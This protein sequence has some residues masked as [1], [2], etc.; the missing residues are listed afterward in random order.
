M[1]GRRAVL[2]WCANVVARAGLRVLRMHVTM[3]RGLCQEDKTFPFFVVLDSTQ[4]HHCRV[5][6]CLAIFAIESS[7]FQAATIVSTSRSNCQSRRRH[8]HVPR[9]MKPSSIETKK[10]HICQL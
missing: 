3:I 5:F 9:H 10:M 2:V 7:R 1:D 8:K 4:C 6:Q